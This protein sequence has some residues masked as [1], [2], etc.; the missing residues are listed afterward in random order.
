MS[1]ANFR[2]RCGARAKRA[3]PELATPAELGQVIAQTVNDVAATIRE[4]G[5]QQE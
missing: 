2:G 3:S 1:L 5:M 4:C